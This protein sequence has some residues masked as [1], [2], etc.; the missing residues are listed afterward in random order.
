MTESMTY[1]LVLVV[2]I[3][4]AGVGVVLQPAQATQVLGFCSLIA[5]SL[6]SLLQ[7]TKAARKVEDVA[8]AAR[9]SARKVDNL[10]AVAE[11]T[12]T[13]TNATHVLVNSNMA[14]QMKIAEVAL[15]RV[16]ELTRHPDDIAAADL[17]E[18]TYLEHQKKQVVVDAG[19][20]LPAVT[21]PPATVTSMNVTAESV[22]VTQAPA[23]A[24]E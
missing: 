18:R 8:I 16:A 3:V 6:L 11:H 7:G 1:S 9:V 14:A 19:P 5:V 4:V 23:D 17:A 2:V 12:Q 21:P 22:N 24:K 20:L 15:R 10:T 13:V